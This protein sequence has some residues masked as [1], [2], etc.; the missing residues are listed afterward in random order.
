MR[1]LRSRM[2]LRGQAQAEAPVIGADG[3]PRTHVRHG[4]S[5]K[6]ETVFWM[7]GMERTGHS[8]RGISTFYPVDAS[9]NLPDANYSLQVD[10]Q[11]AKVLARL[12]FEEALEMV[13]SLKGDGCPKAP[14]GGNRAKSSDGLRGILL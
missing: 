2:T 4:K 11:V 5:R 13:G 9:L 6:L 10:R 8:G 12:S 7:V 14:G 3:A 1:L